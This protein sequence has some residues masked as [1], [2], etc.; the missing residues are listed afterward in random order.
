[1]AIK[2]IIASLD[3]VPEALRELYVKEG[4]SYVLEMDDTEFKGKISEFRNNNIELAKENASLKE[5]AQLAQELKERLAA[6]G[7]VDPAAAKAAMEK[8]HAIEEK[9]LID[10]GEID[11]VVEQR[12]AQR[13]ERLRS[14]AEGKIKALE[15]A[16]DELQGQVDLFKGKLQ[17]E[18][19]DNALQKAV[20]SVAPVR[21]GAMQD[22]LSRGRTIWSLD[23]DG[24]P[25]PKGS[26]GDVMYGKDGT[27][28]ITMEEWAQ[29]LLLEA[30]YLFEGSAGGGANGNIG[31]GDGQKYVNA[32]DQDT[33]NAN[34]EAI[35]NGEVVVR[36]TS[37]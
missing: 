32:T 28:K 2:P 29:G 15:K 37:S 3:E 7:D 18:V 20:S 13:V 1:M 19:V 17:N 9:K 33:I 4:D 26:D 24:M 22:I 6:F 25:I 8:M 36:N 12:V 21:K 11:Q 30:P 16:K 5:Q 10:A 31:S 14:D 27:K 35:A 23:D 34:I